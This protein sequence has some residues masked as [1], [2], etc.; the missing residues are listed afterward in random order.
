MIK[1]LANTSEKKVLRKKYSY[2]GSIEASAAAA[3]L[4][5]LGAELLTTFGVAAPLDMAFGF[6]T[7]DAFIVSSISGAVLAALFAKGHFLNTLM[8]EVESEMGRSGW[9]SK[10]QVVKSY[11]LPRSTKKLPPMVKQLSSGWEKIAT[12]SSHS[13]D[14][15]S[16]YNVETKVVSGIFNS[17]IE[18][19]ITP[20]PLAVWDEAFNSAKE[21]Y[22][23]GTK[24]AI[25]EKVGS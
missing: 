24:T 5:L 14:N 2:I 18:Q 12:P 8:S 1:V 17:Y 25:R 16:K 21:I 4:T 20:T 9:D 3:P 22:P 11:L 6:S 15:A 13:Y 10:F 7:G 19:T 23:F